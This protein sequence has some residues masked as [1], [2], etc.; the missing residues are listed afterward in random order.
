MEGAI[1]AILA[2][3]PSASVNDS[4]MG[5]KTV[6]TDLFVPPEGLGLSIHLVKSI[7]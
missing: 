5:R 2:F 1:N 4:M 7:G 3:V 6:L